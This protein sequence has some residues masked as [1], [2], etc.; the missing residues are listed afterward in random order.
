MIEIAAKEDVK[1]AASFL[2]TRGRKLLF[3]HQDADGVCAAA[4]VLKFFPGF[5]ALAREGPRMED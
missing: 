3:Y 1:R 4:L 2:R 5:E